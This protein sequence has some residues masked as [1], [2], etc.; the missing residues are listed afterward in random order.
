MNTTIIQNAKTLE[1]VV[2]S[3]SSNIKELWQKNSKPIKITRHSKVWWNEDCCLSLEKYHLSQNLENQHN[4][5]SIVKKTKRSFFGDKIEEIANKKC[6]PWDLM[7]QVKKYKLPA[8]KAIQYEGYPCIELGDLWIALHNSF[9]SAQIREID[10]HIL[11]KIPNKPMRS[12]NSFSKQELINVIEKCNNS[13]ALDL[14][15][16]T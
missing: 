6:S 14:D 9:N 13:F 2:Q 16:L 11:D 15:K 3:I 12:W 4:F 1:E 8:I 7:N 5:K 10:I